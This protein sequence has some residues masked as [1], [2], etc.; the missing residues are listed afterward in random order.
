[1]NRFILSLNETQLNVS[2]GVLLTKLQV[3]FL[4]LESDLASLTFKGR[5]LILR[6]Q[7]H[8]SLWSGR[9]IDE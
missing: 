7:F 5:F 8:I 3:L 6:P 4:K 1:M 9:A 2:S